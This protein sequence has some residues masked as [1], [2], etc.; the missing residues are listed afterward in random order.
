[1]GVGQADRM[2][3]HDLDLRLEPI[4][5]E[6]A[7]PAI[8]AHHRAQAHPGD[9]FLPS[10]QLAGTS[11]E[12]MINGS[13]AGVITVADGV[14]VLCTLTREAKKYDRQVVELAIKTFEATKAFAATWDAHHLELFGGFATEIANQ[15]YQL[16]LL[17]PDQLVDPVAGITLAVATDADLPYLNGV[18]F[19]DDY[20]ELLAA[21]RV[22]IARRDETVV[23][24]GL[25]VQHPLNEA[26][27]DL[28]MFTDPGARRQGVGRS[29]IALAAREC[30]DRGQTPVAG[31]WYANWQSRP[32]LEAAGLTCAGT[33]FNF[34]LDPDAFR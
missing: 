14:L 10:Q 3:R 32:T 25:L 6:R 26:V 4:D 7:R 9:G 17:D 2:I 8:D 18:D 24:I 30:L 5:Q 13:S 29:I 19:V 31:C 21:G 1:V 20:T 11:A 12:I 33:I 22:R 34:T 23:G 15:A 28:G 27:V 16:E